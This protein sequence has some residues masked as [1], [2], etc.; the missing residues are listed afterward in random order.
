MFERRTEPLLPRADFVRRVRRHAATA[1]GIL[2]VSLL[3]GVLG[4][5]VLEHLSWVDS[6]LNASMIL[7]GM[8]PVDTLHTSVA[9]VFASLYALYAGFVA[10]VTAGVMFAP[11]IHRWLHRFHLDDPEDEPDKDG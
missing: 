2:L 11:I 10:L 5:H 9:K 1:V 7:G 3:A 6:L 4:Y 8:G